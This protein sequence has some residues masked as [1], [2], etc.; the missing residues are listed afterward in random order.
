MN[1]S[2]IPSFDYR[3]YAILYVDDEPQS[4]SN[5]QAYFAD[6]FEV[7]IATSGE[8]AW[9]I[10]SREKG[11]I[12]IV[13]ADQRMPGTTGVA[14]LTRIKETSPRVIRVLAT[15]FTELETA[16]FAVNDGAI[17]KYITKP[18]DPPAL[19][20]TLKRGMEFF[21]T[22]E[23]RQHKV[24]LIDTIVQELKRIARFKSKTW[25]RVAQKLLGKIEHALKDLT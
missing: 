22:E 8:E 15:A 19:E 5:F 2:S 11:R 24:Q 23:E 16:I 20:M 9:D 4:V 17:Y 14:L 6:T 7:L 21:L 1:E 10:F 25:R 13:V 18:W 3:K 12:A